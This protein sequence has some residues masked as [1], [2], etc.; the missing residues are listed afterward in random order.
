MNVL[1]S[2]REKSLV[3]TDQRLKYLQPAVNTLTL[4]TG[5]DTVAGGGWRLWQAGGRTCD[6]RLGV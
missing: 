5:R 4:K 2:H 1:D 3:T 6:E